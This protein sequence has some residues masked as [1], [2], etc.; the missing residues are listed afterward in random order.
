[1][2]TAFEGFKLCS[3]PQMWART[4]R[5]GVGVS[6]IQL[7]YRSRFFSILLAGMI[8]LSEPVVMLSN[9]ATSTFDPSK[10]DTS[11]EEAL[12][13]EITEKQN[14]TNQK[15]SDSAQKKAAVHN[16]VDNLQGDASAAKSQLDAAT[17]QLNKLYSKIDKTNDQIESTTASIEELE[18][19]IK[20]IEKKKKEQYELMKKRVAFSYERSTGQSMFTT[21][22]DSGSVTSFL[23]RMDYMYAV[24]AYDKKVMDDFTAMQEEVEEKKQKLVASKEELDSYQ[25]ELTAT[26]TELG[27]I[28]GTASLVYNEKNGQ[29]MA[30]K[31]EESMLDAEI[32]ELQNQMKNLEAQQAAAQ[33]EMARK[34]A[35]RIAA[36]EAERQRKAAEEEARRK[37]EEEAARAAAEANGEEYVPQEYVP[38]SADNTPSEDLS[39]PLNATE[40]DI[41]LLA[42]TIQAEAGNHSYDGK[43]AV[44]SVVANRVKSRHFPNSIYG[45]V[46]QNMQFEPWRKGIIAKF[47]ANGPN[48]TC[49]NVAREVVGGARNGSWLFFM[50]PNWAD[51][52]GI[53]GYQTMGG[54]AFFWRWGAN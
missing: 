31:A 35:E 39:G 21:F 11:A 22:L 4:N 47:M 40:E 16:A 36:E 27:S 30:A 33:A 52:Y 25:D 42:A 41:I 43:L 17:L 5:F 7:K 38:N 28:V 19:Q 18:D 23:N 54:H 6:M 48:E 8:A 44:G 45:V 46:S 49:M 34:I 29:V 13:Q 3:C 24:A 51:Y 20:E 2:V 37:A 12:S 15:L 26:K 9:A 10:Y 1:M 50:T 32:Q 53:T 14:E